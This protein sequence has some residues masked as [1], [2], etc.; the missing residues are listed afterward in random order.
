MKKD[1]AR[2]FKLRGFPPVKQPSIF[3]VQ[4]YKVLYVEPVYLGQMLIV[5]NE[6]HL[7]LER[8]RG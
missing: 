7:C 5:A 8:G 3:P 1:L 2:S 4:S 6:N